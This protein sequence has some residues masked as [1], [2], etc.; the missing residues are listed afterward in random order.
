MYAI[1]SYYDRFLQRAQLDDE[2]RV[3]D[4]AERVVE[5][6]A[7]AFAV[8]GAAQRLPSSEEASYL[9]SIDLG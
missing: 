4:L 2:L 5:H 8:A 7:R 1:R 3:V 6:R 9:R